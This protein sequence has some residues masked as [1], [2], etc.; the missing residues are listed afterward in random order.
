MGLGWT[1]RDGPQLAQCASPGFGSQPSSYGAEGYYG[2]ISIVKFL[3]LLLK[4]FCLSEQSWRMKLAADNQGLH[5]KIDQ[6]MA[7][8]DKPFPNVT[9]GP[10]YNL[11]KEVVYTV[12][13]SNLA[14]SHICSRSRAST[15]TA[16]ADLDLP[17]QLNVEADRLAGIFCQAN[18]LPCPCIPLLS[19][20]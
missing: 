7:Y 20:Y 12:C 16:I 13:Q 8:Y 15:G 10:Y 19:S 18:P 9:L 5:T 4:L 14:S 6:S 17:S 11:I 2:V 1:R 3:A